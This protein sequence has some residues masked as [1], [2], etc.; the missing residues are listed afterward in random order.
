MGPYFLEEA[1]LTAEEVYFGKARD[2][3][4][5]LRSMFPLL[6][7]NSNFGLIVML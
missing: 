1:N 2:V 7:F 4:G 6:F 5:E 3:V